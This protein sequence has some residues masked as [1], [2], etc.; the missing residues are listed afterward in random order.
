MRIVGNKV[1]DYYDTCISQF[2]YST[3]GNIFLR[4]PAYIQVHP[5]P[6]N[7]RY[8]SKV[9]SEPH[10]EYTFLGKGL[11]QLQVEFTDFDKKVWNAEYFR[12][13]FAG[14]LYGGIHI[15]ISDRFKTIGTAKD[16]EYF[17][18]TWETFAEYLEKNGMKISQKGHFRWSEDGKGTYEEDIR[19]H[20]TTID[21]TG[22]A[23]AE[24]LV[25]AYIKGGSRYYGDKFEVHVNP[26]LKQFAFF[27]LF[28]PFTAY[29]ELAMFVDGQLAYPGNVMIEI[30][31][32]YR[33]AAHGFDK[34]SF[35]K[36]PTKRR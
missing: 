25:I 4:E 24:K 7:S 13:L 11:R 5:S 29:Q 3:E 36:G 8:Y 31:D 20:F 9:P 23:A 16:K 22:E 28:D 12:I 35:R 26:E 10:Q 18:Y 14:K 15:R 6:T 19:K 27:K 17:F 1:N 32:K 2:G 34:M 33:I 21:V 30:E